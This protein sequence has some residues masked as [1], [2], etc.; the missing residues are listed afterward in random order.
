V[1]S[2]IKELSHLPVIVDPSHA[3]GKVTLVPRPVLPRVAAGADGLI[4]EVHIKP[5]EALCDKEQALTPDQ[6]V[7]MMR[8]M[9]ALHQFM[10]NLHDR[11]HGQARRTPTTKRPATEGASP[12]HKCVVPAAASPVKIYLASTASERGGSHGCAGEGR[13]EPTRIE[14]HIEGISGPSTILVGERWR[15]SPGMST[16][17]KRDRNR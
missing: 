14:L 15:A 8:K 10:G 11:F 16:A 6:F 2:P 3:V 1:P 13:R 12:A 4:V 17:L 9:S 5:E 7:T